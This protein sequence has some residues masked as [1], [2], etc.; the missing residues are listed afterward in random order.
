MKLEKASLTWALAH[1]E[2]Y[3]DTDI[4]PVPFEYAAIRADWGALLPELLE[5][6]LDRRP[7]RE[8]RRTLTPKS[9]YGFRLATQLDPLDALLFTA[10]VYEIARD[11]EHSRIPASE[12]TVMSHRVKRAHNGQLYNPNFTFETFKQRLL[13][14]SRSRPNGWVVVTDIADFY[15]RLYHHPLEN[16]LKAATQKHAHVDVVMRFLS[17]WNYSVSYGIP[18]GPA[19]SR[20]LAEVA[21]SD[22]DYALIDEGVDFCR[23]SDDFR[24]FA[25]SERD[26]F[27]VL[28]VLASYLQE[29]HGL[30][31]SERKTDIVPVDRFITRFLEGTRPGDS[32]RL[33]DRVGQIL[34]K[35]G[36]QEDAYAALDVEELPEALV[37]ELDALDL[38]SVLQEQLNDHRMYDSF[39]VS[40]ALRRLGQL[41]DETLL[42]LVVNSVDQLTSVLPQVVTFIQK[43]TPTA[44]RAEIRSRLLG[45]IE[46][47]A[48]GH[49]EYQRVWLLSLFASDATWDNRDSLVRLLADVRDDVS[50]PLLLQALGIAAQPHWFRKSRREIQSMGGWERRSFIRGAMCMG[51]DEYVHWMKSLIPRLDAL[52]QLVGRYCLASLRATS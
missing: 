37:Q 50:R 9:R 27:R 8:L 10:T 17:Q 44:R 38:N 12:N 39:A 47:G 21:L 5:T 36:R 35:Y 15:S 13:E 48:S 23:F 25:E 2:R 11:L 28:A 19:A 6:E 22:V 33:A 32:A 3:G 14:K 16:A 20:I 49:Q 40:I 29:N 30:T 18:V 43:V 4:F 26:A 24:M 45:T 42:D 34:E 31:L 51:R 1:I 41:R 46:A 7:A 52:D